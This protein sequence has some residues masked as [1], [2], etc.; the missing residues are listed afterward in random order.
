M[1]QLLNWDDALNK[2]EVPLVLVLAIL[3]FYIAFGGFLFACFEPWT[4][5]DAFYF[6][7]VSLTTI[8]FGDLVPEN[9][10]S[11]FSIWLKFC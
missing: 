2:A 9:Q 5:T 11:A 8:G 1:K 7:F 3:L 4:Y 10:E 6:C